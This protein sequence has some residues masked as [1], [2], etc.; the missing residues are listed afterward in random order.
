LISAKDNCSDCG[1]ERMVMKFEDLPE[2]PRKAFA[3]LLKMPV[4]KTGVSF[5]YCKCCDQYSILSSPY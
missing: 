4:Y 3:G 5:L 2:V 1:K